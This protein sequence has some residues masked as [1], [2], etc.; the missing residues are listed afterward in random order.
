MQQ[1][2]IITGGPDTGKSSIINELILQKYDCMPEISRE[3]I[4]KT[5]AKGIDQLFLKDPILFIQLLLEDRGKQYL[6]AI[7]LK[8]STVF[9]DRGNPDVPGCMKYLGVQFLN[10]FWKSSETYRYSIIIMLLPWKKTYTSDHERYGNF[11][12]SVAIHN[13]IK[14]TYFELDYKI[15]DVPKIRLK[16]RINNILNSIS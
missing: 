14:N 8:I 7:G 3:K 12:Q 4:L 15:I 5:Q 16:E 9:F 13:Y 10:Y 6:E 1:K 11:K 2:I